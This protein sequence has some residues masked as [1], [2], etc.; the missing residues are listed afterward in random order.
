MPLV[1]NNE[2]ARR[3][4]RF[5]IFSQSGPVRGIVSAVAG[6]AT[7]L[8]D[9]G[10]QVASIVLVNLDLILTAGSETERSRLMGRRVQI[11]DPTGQ[12]NWG[13]A[14]CVDVY[15]RQVNAEGALTIV[16]LLQ[17]EEGGFAEVVSSTCT[18]VS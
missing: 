17:L 6:T 16:A 2:V 9:N 12:T 10:S 8:W 14:T 18:V 3:V 15:A 11:N 5:P 13:R 4:A 7:V 1:A